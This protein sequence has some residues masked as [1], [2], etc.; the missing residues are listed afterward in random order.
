MDELI[1]NIEYSNG[2]Y[3]EKSP[4]KK[5]ERNKNINRLHARKFI[6]YKI[7]IVTAKIPVHKYQEKDQ[8]YRNE[9]DI[10]PES[11][12]KSRQEEKPDSGIFIDVI[13]L[14]HTPKS[15]D[16]TYRPSSDAP[17]SAQ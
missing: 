4:A 15:L 1:K 8:R 16:Y 2:S 17:A 14:S 12:E 6:I 9:P 5:N 10:Q 3:A 7:R 11:Y 13:S